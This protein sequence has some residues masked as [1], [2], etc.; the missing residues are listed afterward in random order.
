MLRFFSRSIQNAVPQ[1]LYGAVMAQSRDPQFYLG[2][3]VP[4]TVLGRF[5][6]VCLHVYLLSRRLAGEGAPEA[7][8]LSQAVFDAFTGGL[9]MALRELGVGDTSVPKRMKRMVRG[10]YAQIEAFGP[11]LDAGD[12]ERLSVQLDARFDEVAKAGS[13]PE[14]AAYMISTAGHLAAQPFSAIAAGELTWPAVPA[15]RAMGV[16]GQPAEARNETE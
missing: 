1:Q 15:R 4:D 14:L 13:G 10:F 11:G 9:E 12:A 5:D 3:G 6:M 2:F 16:V 8:A 7:I